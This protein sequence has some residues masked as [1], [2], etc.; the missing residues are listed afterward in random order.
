M[1]IYGVH[2]SSQYWTNPEKFNPSRFEKEEIKKR[3]A[4]A[5]LPFG[6][7]PRLCIGSNFA[8]M[9]MKLILI[10]MLQRFDFELAENKTVSIEPMI[11]LRPE[12]GIWVRVKRKR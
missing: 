5:Y 4:F 12:N 1:Y 9:E 8:M 11:T 10:R 2:R 6:G 3:P 7:G